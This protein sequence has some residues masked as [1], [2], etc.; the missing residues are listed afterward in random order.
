MTAEDKSET[1]NDG[2]EKQVIG[3]KSG[4]CDSEKTYDV[5]LSDV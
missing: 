3:R 4:K 5:G 2:I 1:G